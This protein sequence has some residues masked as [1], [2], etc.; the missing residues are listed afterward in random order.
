MASALTPSGTLSSSKTTLCGNALLLTNSTVSPA[1]TVMDG[2]CARAKKSTRRQSLCIFSLLSSGWDYPR[3]HHLP[4]RVV[5]HHRPPSRG[6]YLL[7]RNHRA[8][9]ASS[10]SRASRRR[11]R[12]KKPS[13]PLSPP[14]LI[15]A[16][17]AGEDI[18]RVVAAT[19]AACA[20]PTSR[21]GRSVVAFAR[22]TRDARRIAH[23]ARRHDAR[24]IFTHPSRAS[25]GRVRASS[26]SRARSFPPPRDRIQSIDRSN[27]IRS[28]D[29]DDDARDDDAPS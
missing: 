14:S 8:R 23:R 11:A 2:G 22:V 21:D 6:P 9:V 25:L 20:R 28:I 5:I 1:L 4:R 7:P 29:R 12:T 18:A 3:H 10:S 19:T 24:I 17:N 27:P 13:S 15:V 26:S 16:A